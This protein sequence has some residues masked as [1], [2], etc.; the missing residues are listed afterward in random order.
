MA[1]PLKPLERTALIAAFGATDNVL[2]RTRGG[3][4]PPRYPAQVF[5]RRLVNWLYERAMIDYDDPRFP[6]KATL[7]KLGKETADSLVAAAV[8]KAG[9]A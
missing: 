8:A 6:T 4:C 2:K 1:A 3:F 5:S 7:T 9:V